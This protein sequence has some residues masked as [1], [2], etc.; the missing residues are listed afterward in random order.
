MEKV[1]LVSMSAT[2]IYRKSVAYLMDSVESKKPQ[3]YR[4]NESSVA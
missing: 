4:T 3:N 1:C 2:D